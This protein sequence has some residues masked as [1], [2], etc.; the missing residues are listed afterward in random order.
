MAA[1]QSIQKNAEI[2]SDLQA[3]QLFKGQKRDGSYLPDYSE[4][5]VAIFGKPDGPI[6]LN[7]TGDFYKGFTLSINETGFVQYSKDDKNDMLIKKYGKNIFGLNKEH[8]SEGIP[9]IRKS[10]FEFLNEQ[11]GIKLI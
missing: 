7:D 11:S 10:I 8:R 9:Y 2:I 4:N 3:T 6:R 5:S 1:K